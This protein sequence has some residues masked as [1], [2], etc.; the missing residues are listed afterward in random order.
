MHP[1]P[2]ILLTIYILLTLIILIVAAWFFPY[3]ALIITV[4]LA[5]ISILD[6][7]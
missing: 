6:G 7:L 2:T 1:I 5:L 3:Q 4:F